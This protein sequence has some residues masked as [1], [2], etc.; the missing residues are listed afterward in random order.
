[1]LSGGPIWGEGGGGGGG[2][3]KDHPWCWMCLS[4][5]W[6]PFDMVF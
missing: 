5:E 1:M 4:V 2:G 6:V 3:D